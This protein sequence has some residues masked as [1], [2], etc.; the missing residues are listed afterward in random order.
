MILRYILSGG[1]SYIIEIA[2]LYLLSASGLPKTVAV[3]VSFWIGFF[4][5][6]FAQKIFTFK[7]TKTGKKKSTLQVIGYGI[8]VTVNYLFTI[9]LVSIFADADVVIVRTIALAITTSWNFLI[10]KFILFK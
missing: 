3:S 4:V 9:T 1:S 2:I 7:N 8:L 5:S 6:F 10:Y